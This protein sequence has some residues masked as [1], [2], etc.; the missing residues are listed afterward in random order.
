MYL[1]AN[2][3]IVINSGSDEKLSYD[4]RT[5]LERNKTASEII[6]VGSCS[7]MVAEIKV[8]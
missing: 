4:I 7:V 5:I 2:T 1:C 6:S 8:G 3:R